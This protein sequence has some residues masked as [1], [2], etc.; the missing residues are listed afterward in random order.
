MENTNTN[1]NTV[2]ALQIGDVVEI[3]GAYFSGDNGLYFVEH[4]PGGA[5][6][7]GSDY[8]LRRIGK[9][10]KPLKNDN[11]RFWPLA[12]FVSD[13]YKRVAAREHNKEN[14][15]I[16]RV[17]GIP[18]AGVA[19]HFRQEL[20]E[21]VE[22][23]ER[24]ERRGDY[25][26][27]AER[28]RLEELREVCRRFD[29]VEIAQKEPET[30]IKFYWNGLKV[31]G[32]DL[33]K[34]Y[35]RVNDDASV[36]IYADGYGPDLPREYFTVKNDSDIYTDYFDKD[37]AEVAP[38]HPLYKYVRYAAYKAAKR[39]EKRGWGW[40]K[41]PV[42]EPFP[43]PGQPTPADL[44]AVE[45]LK[46]AAESARLAAEHAAQLAE[47]E[48]VLQERQDGR[49]YIESV[50]AEHPAEDGAPVVEITFSEHP[51]FMS[52]TESRDRVAVTITTDGHGRTVNREEKIIEPRRRLLLSVAAAD[53]VLR[54][55][56]DA[57][58]A[59]E[60]GY[61]KTDFVITWKDAETGEENTYSGRYDIGDGDGGLV[62]HVRRLAEW[63][64]DHAETE[65]EKSAA[66]ERLATADLLSAFLPGGRVVNVEFAP[67]LLAALE[68]KKQ[69][70]KEARERFAATL[71]MVEMLTDE[72][73]ID[74]AN[75][76]PYTDPE[77]RDVGRFFLQELAKRDR[78]KALEVFRRWIK[79]EEAP[80][81]W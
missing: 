68:E 48:R 32:G 24:E 5:S 11:T 21:Y 58:K 18:L 62:S 31:N 17:D 12:S 10:G 2:D 8:S 56:D 81:E 72:Q 34:C 75:D 19:Q 3:S 23:I 65:D 13:P 35:Y 36:T 16:V 49:V 25:V 28:G 60:K 51:A 71:E 26:S 14:A 55:Y 40:N 74:A 45:D 1:K 7:C 67:W 57:V 30:G 63:A 41:E 33:I 77:R 4:V 47:R 79:G 9:T 27:D 22:R 54:H 66:A 6:W 80:L 43:D 38:A 78:Q 61:Y 42:V 39:Q 15:K 64:R 59:I 53:I 44:A 52:W 50:A 70:E 20:Q 76:N 69:R 73:L 37:S 46:T 29:G